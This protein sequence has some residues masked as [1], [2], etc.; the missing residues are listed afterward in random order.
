MK[1]T[2]H[3]SRTENG[4]TPMSFPSGR[5]NHFQATVSLEDLEV[6]FGVVRE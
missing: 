3:T 5:A 6:T 4:N 2:Y 1:M